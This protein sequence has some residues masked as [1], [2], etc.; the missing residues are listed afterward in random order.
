[1]RTCDGTPVCVAASVVAG[2]AQR[3]VSAGNGSINGVLRRV[4]EVM[5]ITRYPRRTERS[6]TDFIHVASAMPRRSADA[7][8]AAN[9]SGVSRSSNL[10][11]SGFSMGGLPRFRFSV[12][13]MSLILVRTNN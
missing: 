7:L 12:V 10:A 3:S 2:I 11:V 6:K 5:Q 9:R 4:T 8:Y 13:S 1:M